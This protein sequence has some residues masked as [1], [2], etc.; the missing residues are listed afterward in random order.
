MVMKKKKGN[1]IAVRPD[2]IVEAR[3][4]LSSAQNSFMDIFLTEIDDKDSNKLNYTLELKKYAHIFPKGKVKNIYRDLSEA[5]RTFEG[6]GFYVYSEK[7]QDYVWWTWFSKI[8]YSYGKGMIE[9]EI[10][11]S[12]KDI[13]IEMK[14]GSFYNIKYSAHLNNEYSKRIYYMLKQFEDTGWRVDNVDEMRRKFECPESY[15]KYGLF[16]TKVLDVAVKE[17]NEQ[18]DILVEYEEIKQKNKV[19]MI[20]F[21]IKKKEVV[22][23][24]TKLQLV[25][26]EFEDIRQHAEKELPED[27]KDEAERYVIWLSDKID[28][29]QIKTSKK[30][31]M[32]KVLENANTKKDFINYITKLNNKE[33]NNRE[34][35][36]LEAAAEAERAEKVKELMKEYNVSTPEE[37]TAI[38]SEKYHTSM[39]I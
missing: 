36:E 32:K 3:Y 24:V 4:S 37:L 1:S 16:R 10:G 11:K 13:L 31:Y 28:P 26:S 21:Y 19:V 8:T 15:N 9:V 27:Y 29:A 35:E 12:F 14:R 38:L 33:L 18:T 23:V 17:I 34:L 5:V 2:S 6:K 39:R 20:K 25:D 30:A 22:E 7:E